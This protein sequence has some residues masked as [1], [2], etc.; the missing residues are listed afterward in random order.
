M[1]GAKLT[2]LAAAGLVFLFCALPVAAQ[3]D[4]KTVVVGDDEYTMVR[5]TETEAEIYDGDELLGSFER[6]ASQELFQ[7]SGADGGSLGTAFEIADAISTIVN[8]A[9]D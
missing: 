3:M 7:V 6:N 2:A 9:G 8:A 1:K 5:V 4:T